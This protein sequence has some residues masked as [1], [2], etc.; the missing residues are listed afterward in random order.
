MKK[1]QHKTSLHFD[2]ED[3]LMKIIDGRD[4][5]RYPTRSSYVKDIIRQHERT[6]KAVDYE[7]AFRQLFV[8]IGELSQLQRMNIRLD[9]KE[10]K[11]FEDFPGGLEDVEDY[12]DSLQDPRRYPLP[13]DIELEKKEFLNHNRM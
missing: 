13:S 2:F 5:G 11:Y 3:D 12:M 1:E 9:A 4:K 6:L 8:M 7:K 10:G